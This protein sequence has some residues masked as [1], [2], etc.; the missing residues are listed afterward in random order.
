MRLVNVVE[1]KEVVKNFDHLAKLKYSPVNPTAFT[2][3]GLY[4]LATI[5]ASCLVPLLAFLK[6]LMKMKRQERRRWGMVIQGF[7]YG[8]L[9]PLELEILDLE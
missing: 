2:E 3:R 4:M 1:K 6:L 9:C 7:F 8:N 5:F